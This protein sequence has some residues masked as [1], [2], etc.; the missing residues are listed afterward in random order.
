MSK[1]YYEKNKYKVCYR[2]LNVYSFSAMERVRKTN[3]ADV[4]R[5]YSDYP[6]ETCAQRH[7]DFVLK[8]KEIFEDKPYYADCQSA[9][10][11]AYMYS[12]HRCA[13]MEYINEHVI[14][15]IRK[16]VRIY[17]DCALVV[18]YEF[19]NICNQNNLKEI[20]IDNEVWNDRL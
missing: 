3:K 19:R 12:I 10:S 15:Y 20:Y 16:M 7:I 5:Y 17:I 8:S 18:Y 6:F 9:A 4:D 2:T 13:Y 14:N 1:S 11:L